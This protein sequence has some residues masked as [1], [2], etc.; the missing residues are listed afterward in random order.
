MDADLQRRDESSQ[1]SQPEL[2]IM[3]HQQPEANAHLSTRATSVQSPNSKSP[4]RVTIIEFNDSSLSEEPVDH[5]INDDP[6][7][8]TLT[9]L[10]DDEQI[11]PHPANLIHGSKIDVY[12]FRQPIK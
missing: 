12:C 6:N 3:S 4:K 2:A 10:L 9:A 8:T 5:P 11:D 7:Q 1:R